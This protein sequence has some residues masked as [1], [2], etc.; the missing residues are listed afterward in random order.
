MGVSAP[1]VRWQFILDP[2]I[3]MKNSVDSKKKH[4]Y[5]NGVKREDTRQGWEWKH[6]S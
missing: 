1:A 5:R 4:I 2:Q 6:T 3:Y